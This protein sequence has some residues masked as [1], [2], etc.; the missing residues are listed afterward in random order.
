MRK[1]IFFIT[2]LTALLSTF[3][4]AK[5][6]SGV[7][8]SVKSFQKKVVVNKEGKKIVKWDK[9]TK[10]VPKDIVKYVD[11]ITNNTN[12]DI[13]SVK[14]KNSID[15]NTVLVKNSAKSNTKFTTLYSVDGGKTFAKPNELFIKDKNG[16]KKLATIKDYN[17]IEFIVDKVPAKSK[18]NIEYKVKIK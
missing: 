14:V 17:A 4:F 16:K 5:E 2:I 15:S 7:S 6:N 11:T 3:I 1:N 10:V 18:V 9:V 12:S 13:E 8:I